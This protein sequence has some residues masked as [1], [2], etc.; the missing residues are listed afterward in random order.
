MAT[1]PQA[2]RIAAPKRCRSARGELADIQGGYSEATAFAGE[3]ER[4]KIYDGPERDLPEFT[5]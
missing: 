3:I 1:A 2:H 4:P 5:S